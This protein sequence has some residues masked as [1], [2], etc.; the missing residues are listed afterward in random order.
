MIDDKD[1]AWREPLRLPNRSARPPQRGRARKPPGRKRRVR[2]RRRHTPH[3]YIVLSALSLAV[4]VCVL[5]SVAYETKS[6]FLSEIAFVGVGLTTFVVSA[7]FF[8]GFYMAMSGNIPSHRLKVFLPHGA[9]GVLSPLL[10]TL[11]ISVGLDALGTTPVGVWSVICSIGCLALLC[12]QFVMGKAV[13]RREPL[14]IV[15]G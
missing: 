6:I 11:N 5:E 4:I 15:R 10:Y 1:G 3:Y 13:V 2:G 9:V 12:I 14:R 8:W 7:A